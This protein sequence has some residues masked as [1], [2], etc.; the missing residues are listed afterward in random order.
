VTGVLVLSSSGLILAETCESYPNGWAF[1]GTGA[2]SIMGNKAHSGSYAFR[3]NTGMDV[4]P[5]WPNGWA[6]GASHTFTKTVD[7]KSG[8]NRIGRMFR[9]PSP[10]CSILD[11]FNDPTLNS[12]IWVSD[13]GLG[14]DYTLGNSLMHVMWYT[15]RTEGRV[16]IRKPFKVICRARMNDA[17]K[18]GRLQLVYQAD[19]NKIELYFGSDGRLYVWVY[20]A[21]NQVGNYDLG[22]YDTSFH[23]YEVEWTGSSKV[24]VDSELKVN[25]GSSPTDDDWNNAFIRFATQNN[26]SYDVDFVGV[27]P[28]TGGPAGVHQ[29]S[30]KVGATTLFDIDIRTDSQPIVNNYFDS[31]WVSFGAAATGNQTVEA[32]LRN[33]AAGK[34]EVFA[35]YAWDDLILMVDSKIIVHG[36]LGGQK[37]ELYD[38][39]G[40]LRKSGTCPQTG[41]DVELTGIDDLTPT[42]Y[43]FSGYFKVY[44]TGGEALIY[45]S[46][47]DVRWGGDEYTWIPN[48]SVMDISTEH[49]LIYRSGSGLSPTGTAVTVTLKDK[50]TAAPL[51]GKTILW[52]PNLGTCDPESGPTDE[53][54]QASTTFAAGAN[55]GFAG[56]LAQFEGDA[57]YGPSSII[58]PIDIYY[59]QPTPDAGKDF[60]VWICGQEAV[61]AAGNYK[62]SSDF[63]PQ[64]FTFL[65]PMMSLSVGGWWAIEIYRKGTVEFAG[66]IFTRERQSGTNPQLTLTGV[67]EV[68]MVQRRVANKGYTDEPKLI[69]ED[70]LT[71]YPCGVSA[72][73]IATYG[74][75]IKIDATYENLYDA[76]MQIAK[77][78]GW[79]FK[80]NANRTLDFGPSFGTTQDITIASGGELAK[81]THKEDWSQIDTKVYVI[82]KAA[83]AA[84]VSVAE[85]PAGALQYGLIEE[86][87]LEKN[88]EEEGTLD[89][90]AQEI[91]SQHQG[92]KET[93]GP[94]DWIDNLATGTYGPHDS[95]TV[96]DPD[97][98]LSGLYVV[99]SITRDLM[100]A[101]RAGLE[102]S[103]RLD[104]IADAIQSIRKD[105]KD[106]AVA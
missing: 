57:T 31:G 16:R 79:K 35:Y 66:R 62:L 91:L 75:V 90:R 18:G 106:L 1:A 96:I 8:A 71:R 84:L 14:S 40:S 64:S 99:K 78:T 29:F 17:S 44:D 76:L 60:Q 81:S 98:G 34:A 88:I 56:V 20:N 73:N 52:T 53:N 46:P 86:P 2:G 28:A 65:T 5:N 93:V 104:T 67:D 33:A 26:G 72:G 7:V 92:V 9:G 102:L 39:G 49:T 27:E 43:G 101:T 48:Q 58:Q 87:F 69:I 6:T 68:I 89:L 54:G 85:D 80:L 103:N 12:S 59:A 23:V 97:A 83:E 38:S 15:V 4:W 61:I 55:P 32:K 74:A 3:G 22:T 30:L 21:G 13:H 50:E 19:G 41:V 105:V 36:M 25:C 95:V 51:S 70:L 100:D 47:T 10:A 45:T 77:V 63:K 37:I 11:D 42:A 82:G 24:W 94:V